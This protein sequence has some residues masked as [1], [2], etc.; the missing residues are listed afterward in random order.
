MQDIQKIMTMGFVFGIFFAVIAYLG[1]FNIEYSLIWMI[2]FIVAALCGLGTIIAIF[3]RRSLIDKGY[4]NSTIISIISFIAAALVNSLILLIILAY[5]GIADFHP[6]AIFIG[7]I[8]LAMGAIYGIYRYRMDTITEK[9]KFLEEL[10]EKNRLFQE[11]SRKLAITEERNRMSRELHDSVSQGLHGL[12]FTIHSLRNEFDSPPQRVSDILSHMEA[13]AN[14]TLDELRTMIEEL[15]PSLLAEDGLEEAL[16]ATINL[17]SQRLRVPIDI[18]L[19]IPDDLPPELELII[20]RIT[21]E[22]LANIEKHAY[23]QHV[24]FKISNDSNVFRLT[25]RDD[26]Q[27]FNSKDTPSGNGVRNMRQR[28]EEVDGSLNIISKPGVGTSIIVELPLKG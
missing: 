17:V 16:K 4:Y 5:F 18:K 23:P 28:V 26:G 22:A 12:V 25:I 7:I 2:P 6:Q 24:Y 3:I 8:G 19:Q 14:S 15:K 13:T 11:A 21:Q 1:S 10:A 27:G 20:Y 9:M